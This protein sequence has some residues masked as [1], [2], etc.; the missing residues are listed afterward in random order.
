MRL[1][2]FKW[3]CGGIHNVPFLIVQSCAESLVINVCARNPPFF[4]MSSAKEKRCQGREN[5]FS[6]KNFPLNYIPSWN[7]FPLHLHHISFPSPT[8]LIYISPL[9][10]LR[11]NDV[12]IRVRAE[13]WFEMRKMKNLLCLSMFKEGKWKKSERQIKARRRR[14]EKY[15]F[16]VLLLTNAFWWNSREH[17]C[18][19]HSF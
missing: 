3:C 18:S 15:F 2:G 6:E 9:L 17:N 8:I 13:K 19:I 16:G 4:L 1:H 11:K 5:K 14:S 12:Y 7:A 10:P